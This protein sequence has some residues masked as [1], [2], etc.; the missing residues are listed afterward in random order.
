M[1]RRGQKPAAGGR[2]GFVASSRRKSNNVNYVRRYPEA[3][4]GRAEGCPA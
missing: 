3:V 2:P 4:D 1:K